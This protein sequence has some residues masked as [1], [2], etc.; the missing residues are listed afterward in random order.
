[1]ELEADA[2]IKALA[3]WKSDGYEMEDV[4]D[5]AAFF[6]KYDFEYESSRFDEYL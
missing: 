5:Q 4:V 2:A 3:D 6:E 1:M